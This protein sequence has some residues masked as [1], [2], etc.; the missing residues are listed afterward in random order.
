MTMLL[1]RVKEL[2][3]PHL[4][5]EM[6]E[7][8]FNAFTIDEG[9]MSVDV[10]CEHYVDYERNQIMNVVISPK[11]VLVYVSNEDGDFGRPIDFTSEFSDYKYKLFN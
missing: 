9:N 7:V 6:M 3:Q 1:N 11:K 8:G 5:N 2:V 10:E 4:E